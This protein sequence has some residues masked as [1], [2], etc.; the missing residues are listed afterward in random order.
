MLRQVLQEFEFLERQV[1]GGSVDPGRVACFVDDDAGGAD[2]GGKILFLR[3]GARDRESNPGFDFSRTRGVQQ[4]VIHGPGRG[5]GCHAA[6]GEDQHQRCTEPR[7]LEQLREGP[8]TDQV[9]A[10][11]QQDDVAGIRFQQG[12]GL[13]REDMHAVVEQFQG[14]QNVHR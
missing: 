10:G 4:D 3:H 14:R 1:Q 7:G 11:I 2:L 8:R 6:F 13:G 12:S 9:L 5:H